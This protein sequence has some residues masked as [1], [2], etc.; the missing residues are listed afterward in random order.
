MKIDLGTLDLE[1]LISLISTLVLLCSLLWAI[2]SPSCKE[3]KRK[4]KEAS[5]L[6]GSI[7]LYLDVLYDKQ[8]QIPFPSFGVF[9]RVAKQNHDALEQFFL[10]S[11]PLKFEERKKLREFVRFF[12]GAPVMNEEAFPKYKTKLEDLRQVF[13]EKKEN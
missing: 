9:E 4:K 12:K 6:R 8:K 10:V 2:F 7:R 5:F 11:D 3:K 13:T 1:A